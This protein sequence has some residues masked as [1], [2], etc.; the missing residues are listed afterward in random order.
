MRSVVRLLT[1]AAAAV[2]ATFFAYYSIR[3]ATVWSSRPAPR[4]AGMYVG[5]VVFPVLTVV[6]GVVAMRTVRSLRHDVRRPRSATG[7]GAAR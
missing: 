3:L 1:A 7:S 6:L 4:P 2:V 5:A